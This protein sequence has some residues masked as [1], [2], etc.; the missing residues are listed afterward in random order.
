MRLQVVANASAAHLEG[1]ASLVR[2]YGHGAQHAGGGVR[3]SVAGHVLSLVGGLLDQDDPMPLY[4]LKLTSA[5]LAAAPTA[6]LLLLRKCDALRAFSVSAAWILLLCKLKVS[7]LKKRLQGANAS[8]EVK[9]SLTASFQH[10]RSWEE[11]LMA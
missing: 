1:R 9:C 3:E 5:A 7:G 11:I 8:N 6:A 2:G 10:E 4:A